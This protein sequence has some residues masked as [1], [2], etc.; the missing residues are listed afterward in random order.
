MSIDEDLNPKKNK[1]LEKLTSSIDF[2]GKV[3]NSPAH[4]IEVFQIS[5]DESTGELIHRTIYFYNL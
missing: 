5:D 3:H 2:S 4:L 1:I